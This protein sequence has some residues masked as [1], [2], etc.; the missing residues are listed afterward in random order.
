MDVHGLCDQGGAALR[1]GEVAADQVASAARGLD[2]RPGVLGVV[3]LLE[4]GHDDVGPF[5][6]EGNGH[7]AADAGVAA[8]HQRAA[9]PQQPSAFVVTHLVARLVAHLPVEPG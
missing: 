2:Q 6:G 5:L 1:L 8:G 7:R 9:T 3:V 4:V